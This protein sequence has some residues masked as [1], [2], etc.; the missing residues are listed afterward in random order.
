MPKRKQTTTSRSNKKVKKEEE[1]CDSIIEKKIGFEEPE[2]IKKVKT[3]S[4]T[5][6][7]EG[8]S[9]TPTQKNKR[10]IFWPVVMKSL[11]FEC[12]QSKQD[13]KQ[14]IDI[15]E[16]HGQDFI[17]YCSLGLFVDESNDEPSL[18]F[19]IRYKPAIATFGNVNEV[20]LYQL[21]YSP[22]GKSVIKK[23]C[24]PVSRK[25]Y[26]SSMLDLENAQNSPST[27]AWKIS[28]DDG[29]FD[30]HVMTEKASNTVRLKKGSYKDYSDSNYAKSKGVSFFDINEIQD[31]G[32]PTLFDREDPLQNELDLKV[33]VSEEIT[34][35]F[36]SEQEIIMEI[37]DRISK[38]E[39]A[40]IFQHIA[41]QLQNSLSYVQYVQ[42][43][44]SVFVPLGVPNSNSIQQT[45]QEVE[46]PDAIDCG[47]I[48]DFQ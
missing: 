43:M 37:I 44:Q 31:T 30:I 45:Q 48:F 20:S 40:K 27:F 24:K 46:N 4:S 10:K 13:V 41:K 26:Y 47:A 3:G 21:I 28:Y 36:N 2:E 22:L 7:G 18:I 17:Q 11:Q 12:S 9:T 25:E 29:T 5:D 8:S 32:R 38:E 16:T 42:L 6:K 33:S 1:D 34:I 39:Q 19:N 23:D 14:L 35:E 15:T